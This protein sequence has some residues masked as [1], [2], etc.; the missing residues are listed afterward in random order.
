MR[1]SLVAV[2]LICLLSVS[3]AARLKVAAE[4]KRRPCRPQIA[5]C[6]KQ[7]CAQF[8]G[9]ARAGCKRAARLTILASCNLATDHAG[10]CSG[11]QDNGNGC[12]PD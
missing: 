8:H 4:C 12:A 3:H 6:V 2:I 11:L 7:A 9:L 10:F 5:K 1:F